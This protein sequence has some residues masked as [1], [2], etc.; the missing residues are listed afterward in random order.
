MYKFLEAKSVIVVTM[1]LCGAKCLVLV[2][3]KK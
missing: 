3:V 1:W 2:T